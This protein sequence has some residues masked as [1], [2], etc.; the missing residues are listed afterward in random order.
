MGKQER[1]EK[2]GQDFSEEE[3]EPC[4]QG[5]ILGAARQ[6]CK[7]AEKNTG[8]AICDTLY[9]KAVIGE[10]NTEDFLK[11]TRGVVAKDREAR[12]TLNELLNYHRESKPNI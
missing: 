1:I 11:K 3:C 5:V 6:I 8:N 7:L 10:I 4:K 12:D 2:I 9:D